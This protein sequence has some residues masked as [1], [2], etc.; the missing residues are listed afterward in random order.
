M[1]NEDVVYAN[2]PLLPYEEAVRGA[3]CQFGSVY[4]V[5]LPA[6]DAYISNISS[7]P[8]FLFWNLLELLI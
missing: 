4:T 8:K 2:H 5:F 1:N 3:V 6:F 7:I